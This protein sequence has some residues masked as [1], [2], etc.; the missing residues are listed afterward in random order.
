MSDRMPPVHSA[1]AATSIISPSAVVVGSSLM[2]SP[3]PSEIPP[4]RQRVESYGVCS[5]G[6]ENSDNSDTESSSAHASGSDEDG[7]SSGIVSRP[8]PLVPQQNA[9]SP[10][11]QQ[12]SP[13]APETAA[14][15]LSVVQTS[16]KDP[17][18]TTAILPHSTASLPMGEGGTA[19]I[20][21]QSSLA[22]LTA[23]QGGQ[24]QIIFTNAQGTAAI[25]AES[26][27]GAGHM[28]TLVTLPQSAA[29]HTAQ[30]QGGHHRQYGPHRDSDGKYKKKRRYRTN[31]N[32]FQLR[33]LESV[34]EKTHYPD[35]FT[36][37]ELASRVDLTEARVQV[38][39]QNRRAKW[40]KKEK[41]TTAQTA[42]SPVTQNSDIALAFTVPVST[43]SST[44]SAA[45]TPTAH[46]ATPTS[47][48]I[49]NSAA[50]PTEVKSQVTV[51]TVPTSAVAQGG[52][53]TAA[54]AA[55]GTTTGIQV[56]GQG[57][58]GWPSLLSPITYIPASLPGGATTILTPQVFSTATAARMPILT[59]PVITPG[60]PQL[61]TLGQTAAAGV[62]TST[63]PMIQ[64]AIP[65]VARNPD[66]TS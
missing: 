20:L 56:I 8:P 49:P 18:L 60:T 43:L 21:P 3:P 29:T 37:E 42:T 24:R 13:A 46:E 5:S 53:A 55:A 17:M 30:L 23:A 61:L 65:Q 31:F 58:V 57:G 7:A 54:A 52:V 19:I 48:S 41:L 45:T 22:G 25:S 62:R 47:F 64:V 51:L 35:V 11:L 34:F 27:A 44:I 50:T 38:W 16:N 12:S 40:R 26:L 15:P 36:R 28:A 9:V 10:T 66:E 1:P 39:F 59:T 14:I 4:L 33:E 2:P 32:S 63:V 6:S